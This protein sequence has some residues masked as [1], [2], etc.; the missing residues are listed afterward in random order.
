MEHRAQEELLAL[1]RDALTAGG[2]PL[3]MRIRRFASFIRGT[4][5]ALCDAMA[6]LLVSTRAL[7]QSEIS[8]SSPVDSDSRLNLLREQYPVCLERQPVFLPEIQTALSRL[9][10]ER[11]NTDKLTAAGLVP[12]RSLLVSGPPGVGKTLSASWIAQELDL[13]LLT[14]DLASVISSYL[15]KTGNNVRTVLNYAQQFPCVLLLDEFDAI[16]KRRD[17]DRDVGEL[18]RLVT[19]LLQTIDEWSPVSVLIAATNHGEL[20]DP[21]I[22]R[23]F[24]MTIQMG[25]PGHKEREAFLCDNGIDPVLSQWVAGETEGQ[26]L[27]ALG[28][29]INTAKK[30]EVLFGISPAESFLHWME[31]NSPS[32]PKDAKKEKKEQIRQRNLK[33]RL[34]FQAGKTSREIADIVNISHTTVLRALK[35]GDDGRAQFTD[36]VR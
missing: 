4:D 19:V 26:S 27:A 5:P 11:R 16:A 14:L 15:G 13:P 20:L 2:A 31:E 33:I 35:E 22:W 25:L 28:R 23:R 10:Q 21:A 12:L 34:H 7:R 1:F 36:R 30:A 18:K 9:I 8:N 6:P 24:D 29:V 3:E 17:D 32:S